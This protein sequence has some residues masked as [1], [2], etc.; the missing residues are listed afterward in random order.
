MIPIDSAIKSRTTERPRRRPEW[1][2][3]NATKGKGYE[4]VRVLMRNKGLNT[5]C[6]EARCP[7]IGEC[8]GD[9]T[10]TFLVLG[11]TCTR[12]C[13]FCD[14]KTGRPSPIDWHE[15]ERVARAVRAMGLQHVV[16][17]SV[18]RDERPDGGAPVIAL[19]IH[20]IREL[21]D[22]TPPTPSAPCTGPTPR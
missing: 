12:S 8:W 20:R 11:D 15:P 1:M 9:G 17:T 14:I 3:V 22:C 21:Q 2:R 6:E 4:S 5:V 10:A 7:N 19:C 16:V 18:N 13:G